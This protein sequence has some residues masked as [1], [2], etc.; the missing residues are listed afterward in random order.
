MKMGRKIQYVNHGVVKSYALNDPDFLM[1]YR[2]FFIKANLVFF[3]TSH[4][5]GVA[6]NQQCVRRRS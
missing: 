4:T 3:N 1:I 6:P 5:V 2:Y